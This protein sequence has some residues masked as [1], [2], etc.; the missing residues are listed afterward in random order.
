MLRSPSKCVRFVNPYEIL[1]THHWNTC[2]YVSCTLRVRTLYPKGTE[3]RRIVIG[4]ASSNSGGSQFK[5][6]LETLS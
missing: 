2:V 5:S 3:R 1:W 4:T 6:R